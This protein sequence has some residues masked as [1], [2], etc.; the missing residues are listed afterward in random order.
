M[1]MEHYSDDSHINAGTGEGLSIGEL[2]EIRDVVY[3]EAGLRFDN[4]KPDGMPRKLL[5]VT[6]RRDLGW[7]AS[8]DLD[9]G[10]RSTYE[11][12]VEHETDATGMIRGYTAV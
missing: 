4:S 8:I 1:L 7:H 6:R 11:W 10:I 12:L 2:A 5:D 9:H 3:R